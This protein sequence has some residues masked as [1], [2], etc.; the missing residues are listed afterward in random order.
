MS[1]R[2]IGQRRRKP[3]RK[4]TKKRKSRKA[5]RSSSSRAQPS[6]INVAASQPDF[7]YHDIA[8]TLRREFAGYHEIALRDFNHIMQGIKN[9]EDSHQRL[10]LLQEK[11]AKYETPRRDETPVKSEYPT[12]SS[13]MEDVEALMDEIE[14]TVSRP[15]RR[16]KNIY[17]SLPYT[18]A[19]NVTPDG[20]PGSQDFDAIREDR[21]RI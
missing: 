15:I 3:K 1:R 4:G 7:A 11:Q 5:S 10:H 19:A 18:P 21:K 9:T 20:T 17:E 6:I 14:H 16:G 12:P 2:A 13:R 8:G